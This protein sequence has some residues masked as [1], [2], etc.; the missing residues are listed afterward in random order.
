MFR[1]ILFMNNKRVKHTQIQL[2]FKKK[3][4]NYS[5][6]NN[7]VYNIYSVIPFKSNTEQFW[8]MILD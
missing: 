7:Y 2:K 1:Y 6:I 8:S 4:Y 5:S 3:V